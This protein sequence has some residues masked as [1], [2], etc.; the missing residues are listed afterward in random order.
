ME[1]SENMTEATFG[2]Y[3]NHPIKGCIP[4]TVTHIKFGFH[5]NQSIDGVIPLTVTRLEFGG[6][7]NKPVINNIPL[8][9][10]YLSFGYSFNQPVS[11]S[12][13]TWSVKHLFFGL[14]F[15]RYLSKEILFTVTH[16][17]I[18]IGFKKSLKNVPDSIVI[19]WIP[20]ESKHLKVNDNIKDKIVYINKVTCI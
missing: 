1:L 3:F 7:F 17:W 14:N 16:L 13:F 8:S 5:F 6:L 18:D 10:T 2:H 20:S 9:V 19:V 15:N 4:I 11:D 12:N